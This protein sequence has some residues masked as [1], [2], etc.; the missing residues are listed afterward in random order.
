MVVLVTDTDRQKLFGFQ[1]EPLT[2]LS[3]RDEKIQVVNIHVFIA[4]VF[5]LMH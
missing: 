4:L 2:V 1:V 5:F 3:D